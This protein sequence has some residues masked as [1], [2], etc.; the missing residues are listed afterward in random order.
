MPAGSASRLLV[1]A[2]HLKSHAQVNAAGGDA[3]QVV[4]PDIGIIGNTH[5]TMMDNNSEQLAD[6][7]EKWIRTHVR[8]VKGSYHEH[9]P[10]APDSMEMERACPHPHGCPQGHGPGAPGAVLVTRTSTSPA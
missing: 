10:S 7:I 6:L 9:Q 8:N 1:Q 4:L 3:S 2:G 5:M